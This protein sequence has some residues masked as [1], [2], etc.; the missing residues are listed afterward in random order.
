[1]DKFKW[2]SGGKEVL[3]FLQITNSILILGKSGIQISL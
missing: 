2:P 3:I 1:M